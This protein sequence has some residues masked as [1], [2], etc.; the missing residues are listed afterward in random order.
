MAQ[1]PAN[2]SLA[3]RSRF[4][5]RLALEV[6]T[7]QRIAVISVGLMVFL[8]P[9]VSA[10]DSL[11]FA[12]TGTT[13][14][15]LDYHTGLSTAGGADVFGLVLLNDAVTSSDT[16]IGTNFAVADT[17]FNGSPTLA[18]TNLTFGLL[19]NP[20][21]DSVKGQNVQATDVIFYPATANGLF[22]ERQ[23]LFFGYSLR[24]QETILNGTNDGLW[25]YAFGISFEVDGLTSKSAPSAFTTT[26]LRQLLIDADQTNATG[27]FYEWARLVDGFDPETQ[28]VSYA[29]GSV[30][31]TGTISVHAVPDPSSSLL[32]LGMALASVG[33]FKRRMVTRRSTS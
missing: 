23:S 13:T 4:C 12:F 28:A 31:N 8:F 1:R 27:R 6:S 20:F 32:L 24:S 7:L 33:I 22:A 30:Y 17:Y 10:A 25:E 5:I 18:I 2:T 21:A 9:A 19:P 11:T 29:P 26:S 15:G 14:Q 16:G 3:K